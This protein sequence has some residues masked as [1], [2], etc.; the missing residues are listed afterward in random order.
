M[1]VGKGEKKM[2]SRKKGQILYIIEAT[3][4]YFISIVVSGAYLA[5]VTTLIGMSQ[6]LTGICT[7]FVS[8]GAG[9]QIFALFLA[10]NSR[11][12][13]LV[14]LL[15]TINQ[16]CFGLI[17]LVPLVPVPAVAKHVFFVAFLLAGYVISN[18]IGSPKISWYMMFVGE[19][20]R[21]RFTANK[22]M[23][24][25]ITGMAFSYFVS[26]VIDHFEKTG[27]LS[28][29]FII[30]G[31]AIFVLTMA[32][33]LTLIKTPQCELPTL[34]GKVNF[35]SALK[36]VFSGKRT[37]EVL[38]VA[39]LWQVISCSCV[40]FYGAYQVNT[41]QNHGL[42]FS[43]VFV[44]ILSMGHALVRAVCSRP[45]GKIADKYSFKTSSLLCYGLLGLSLLINVFTVPSNGKVMFSIHY[46][47]YAVSMAGINSS[48][49]NLLYEEVA[50]EQRM[51]AYAVQQS[52]AGVIGFLSALIAGVFVDA[53]HARGGKLL[54]LYAQQWL[55]IWGLLL[56]AVIVLFIAFAM[57]KKVVEKDEQPTV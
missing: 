48:I 11:P 17:Y 8:L 20:E 54:G 45:V 3:L 1:I 30:A 33:T 18:L 15:H 13:R 2:E 53:V 21:G 36:T 6:G 39:V 26:F 32:H 43:M 44:A 37:R 22:E 29:A 14:T 5:K 19:K 28:V 52:V 41:V 25:L 27:N 24:S 56:T 38:F 34:Q 35:F 40:A 16:A 51:C 31:A 12:K 4:E 47:L 50:P 55:T 46:V 57:R 49:I 10:R 9:F 23:V 42:G 7:A